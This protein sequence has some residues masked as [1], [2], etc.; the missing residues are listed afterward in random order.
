MHAG[1]YPNMQSAAQLQDQPLLNFR[2][3]IVVFSL[4][5][6]DLRSKG[7]RRR[8][9]EG[10]GRNP[11]RHPLKTLSRL[12]ALV[13]LGCGPLNPLVNDVITT[14]HENTSATRLY[15]YMY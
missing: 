3:L 7:S 10:R 6:N 2:A 9:G 1:A 11:S 15:M 4:I 12:F 14:M 13:A 5:A 8:K